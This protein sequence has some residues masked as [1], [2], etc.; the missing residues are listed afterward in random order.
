MQQKAELIDAKIREL[1]KPINGNLPAIVM[2]QLNNFQRAI[3]KHID[4]GSQVN[5]FQREWHSLA[6]TFRKALAD[7]RPVLV[8]IPNPQTPSHG[9]AFRG[10]GS[11]SMSGTPTP[12]S[13]G[14]ATP[15]PIDSDDDD[16]PCDPSPVIRRPGQK[17]PL[18]SAQHTP[19][20]IPR[21]VNSTPPVSSSRRF[22]LKEVRDIVEDA[23]FGGLPDRVDPKA[24]ER[25][26]VMS[27]THWEN[28][29][30]EF[31]EGTKVLCKE[32]ISEQIQKVF[33]EYVKT[34]FYEEV[35]SIW[36]SFFKQAI[37][38]QRQLIMQLLKWEL[39]KPKTLND[40]A[41]GLAEAK[42]L[43]LLQIKRRETR[44]GTYLDEQEAVT[45]KI[46]TGQA[47]I[48]RIC[49][50]SDAQLGPDEYKKEIGAMS[51]SFVCR[52]IDLANHEL[53]RQRLL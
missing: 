52:F 14:N 49:K 33:G 2:A 36:E 29:V 23:Y 20:K 51:V 12:A 40:E 37:S 24:T 16:I 47:R 1:P 39:A 3:E 44:A 41:F 6:K 26:I 32:M 53:E 11:G 8:V 38:Q 5:S 46:T 30:N 19:N 10:T 7:S 34:R 25:M 45:G 22:V 31:L 50:V 43:T 35:K 21:T 13:R 42:A 9:H 4:G 15:I 28:P 17:R 18:A 48:E 27:M